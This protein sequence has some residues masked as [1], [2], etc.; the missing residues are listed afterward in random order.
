M[1]QGRAQT[2]VTSSPSL[3]TIGRSPGVQRDNLPPPPPPPTSSTTSTLQDVSPVSS[4]TEEL[5][6]FHEEEEE[7]STNGPA[8]LVRPTAN[9][10]SN[11]VHQRGVQPPPQTYSHH[12]YHTRPVHGS[13]QGVVGGSGGGGGGRGMDGFPLPPPITTTTATTL[14]QTR[15][16]PSQQQQYEKVVFGT[17]LQLSYHRPPG[18]MKASHD[19]QPPLDNHYAMY[20]GGPSLLSEP[21]GGPQGVQ[22]P[23]PTAVKSQ[24]RLVRVDPAHM[25]GSKTKVTIAH[26]AAVKGDVATLVRW[27]R[28]GGCEGRRVLSGGVSE[29]VYYNTAYGEMCTLLCTLTF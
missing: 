18:G 22:A 14:P 9:V 29:R 1:D 23:P 10:P 2:K 27:G 15:P 19:H 8:V 28:E 6:T 12:Q 13:Q 26:D 5:S 21:Y 11:Y 16:A 4:S 24:S 17:D 3:Q 7:T 25:M 20:P